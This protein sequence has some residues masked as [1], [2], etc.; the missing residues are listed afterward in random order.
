MAVALTYAS[1]V[2]V[3]KVGR[4]AGQ[5]AKPRSDEFEERNGERYEAFRG[6]IINSEEFTAEAR[7]PDPDRL[8]A[9]YHQS[10]STLNLLRAF[11]TGGFAA[12]SRVHAWN[13]EFVA[14]SLEG[15]RY[16]VIADEIERALQFMKACGI[17]LHDDSA[18][19]AVDFYTSHEALILN[20]EQALTRRDSLTGDWYDCSAHLLWIGDRTRQLNGA[21]V[22]FLR[23]VSNPLGLKVGPSMGVDELRQLV[24]VL[25][26][27]NVPGRLTLISRMG[28][29]R[30]SELLPPLVE[31]LR[32]DGRREL[33][34]CDPMHGNTFVASGGQKTRHFDDVL[35]ETSQFFL[36][37]QALGTW[38][39]GLHVELTGDDVTEC[40]GGGSRLNETD[41]DVNYTSI[42]DPRL[43]ATQSL[44]MAF[45][46]AEYLQRYAT[47]IGDK[48]L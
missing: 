15:K 7:R 43:N 14:N 34:T 9:A 6:H 11:T 41:L 33:W 8:L 2:P 42:C 25:N 40:L 39:G 3:I 28:H 21:H 5:F 37:H 23:G 17:D 38:P 12:L 16:E 32:D 35:S 19:Q 27:D 30:I 29:E 13:Q 47:P 45:H 36:L 44:D 20:Y 18:L 10:V 31:A 1:G 46:V 22:N 24:E 48:S 26:P 4:I